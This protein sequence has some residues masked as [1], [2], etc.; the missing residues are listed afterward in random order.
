MLQ[1]IQKLE[2]GPVLGGEDW[3]TEGKK[4]RVTEQG[5]PKAKG[6]NFVAAVSWHKEDCGIFCEQ[7]MRDAT[8]SETEDSEQMGE[9]KVRLW[10]EKSYVRDGI[11]LW[12]KLG[13]FIKGL[14]EASMWSSK[15]RVGG[16]PRLR[17]H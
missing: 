13:N 3:R 2:E 4:V 15:R 9:E 8:R 5:V 1:R 7:K 12:S 16:S 14:E 11:R 6:R 17:E 10:L